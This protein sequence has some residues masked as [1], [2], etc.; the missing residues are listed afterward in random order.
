MSLPHPVRKVVQPL[1][2]FLDT[3]AGSGVVL[4]VATVVALVWVNSPFASG[5]DRLWNHRL[6]VGLGQ[7]TLTEDVQHWVNDALMAVSSSSS[8]WR[9][10][11][12]LSSESCA[13][14]VEPACL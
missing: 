12:N 1:R 5:Y 9:S 11:E 6:S 10:N 8:D 4:M 7:F 14:P 2:E 3:E 13:I